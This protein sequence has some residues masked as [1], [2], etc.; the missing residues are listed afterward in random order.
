MPHSS[1]CETAAASY[2]V[3]DISLLSNTSVL[4]ERLCL[5]HVLVQ[6]GD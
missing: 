3:C 4:H 6:G 1:A 5:V 2:S